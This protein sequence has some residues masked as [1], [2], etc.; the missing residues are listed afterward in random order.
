M[1]FRV[2]GGVGEIVGEEGG[3]D[4]GF[5]DDFVV[6]DAVGDFDGGDEAAGVD[7]EVPFCGLGV[8][9]SFGVFANGK[10]AA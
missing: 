8:G 6:E 5:G 3:D 2:E 4:G 10:L 1:A 7:V 9:V